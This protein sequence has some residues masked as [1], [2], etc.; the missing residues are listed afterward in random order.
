LLKPTSLSFSVCSKIF[1]KI[2]LEKNA[3]KKNKLLPFILLIILTVSFPGKILAT[4]YFDQYFG[5]IPWY[6]EKARLDNL[7]LELK[8]EPDFI[9]YIGFRIGLKEN[10]QKI[11]SRIARMK[12]YLVS[13]LKIKESRIVFVISKFPSEVKETVIVLQPLTKKTPPPVF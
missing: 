4:S 8:R 12:K 9:G 5:N 7:A 3:M 2:G 11:N 6:E 1:I 13:N 10:R